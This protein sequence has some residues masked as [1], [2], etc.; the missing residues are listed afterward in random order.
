MACR[1]ARFFTFVKINSGEKDDG[2]GV[3]FDFFCGKGV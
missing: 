2:S 1:K 3:N